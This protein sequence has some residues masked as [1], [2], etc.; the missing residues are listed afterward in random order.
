[1]R[2]R[3]LVVDHRTPTPDQDSGSACTFSYLKI[4]AAEFRV[5]FAPSILD[6]AG[7]YSRALRKL[8]I[9]TVSAPEWTSIERVVEHFAPR[10][11]ILLL[12]RGPTAAR[13]FDLARRVAPKAKILFHPV[14]LHFLRMQ[15]GA[16]LTGDP[17]EAAAAA[18]I[19][20]VE[21]DLI[22][23]ADATIVV[24][25]HERTLLS[26]LVPDATV[27]RIPILREPPTVDAGSQWRFVRRWF[28]RSGHG[29]HGGSP[30]QPDPS[31]RHDIV[32]I[33]GYEHAPNVDAVLWF[34]HEIWPRIRSR[35]LARRF[36]I[37]GSK[38]P[39]EIA[40]LAADDIEVRG[41]V[42]DLAPLFDACRLSVAPLRYGGGIKGKIVTS[43]SHHVPVVATAMAV[44]GMELRHQENVLVADTPDDFADEVIRLS[45]DDALWRQLSINGQQVFRETFA[46]A[47]GA[48]R[49]LAVFKDLMRG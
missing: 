4:L 32:F 28:A 23:R 26:E 20:D 18:A 43:L 35:G 17:A 33:G 24:S 49:V 38:V 21:L 41:Y 2:N 25:T 13:V 30:G 6:G 19:R 14:D 42:P 10:S 27:H 7:R 45:R 36:V 15:R 9:D 22:R 40:A 16:A 48:P 47:A 11:D 5:T 34:V 29:A 44:E 31:G 37:A 3:I 8:G 46:L 39:P 12:Y 1:M